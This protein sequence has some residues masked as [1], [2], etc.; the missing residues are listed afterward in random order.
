MSAE[1]P[2]RSP[3][4]LA[5]SQ[6]TLLERFLPQ[7]KSG[8]GKPGRPGAARGRVLNAILY[9][10]GGSWRRGHV[11]ARANGRPLIGLMGMSTGC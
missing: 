4:D 5:Q 10:P 9:D 2:R 7:P 6:R 8:P 3:S 11:G 1:A